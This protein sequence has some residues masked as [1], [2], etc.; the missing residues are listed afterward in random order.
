MSGQECNVCVSK[1]N[2]I[3]NRKIVC[4]KCE[5]SCCRV[6]IEKY[7]T[8]SLNDFHCMKCKKYWDYE[9]FLR[10]MTKASV[11]R[12]QKSRQ[13]V[14]FEREKAK[15][16]ATQKYVTYQ[17]EIDNDK[18]YMNNMYILINRTYTLYSEALKDY[19]KMLKDKE[20]TLNRE[21]IEKS[22]KIL[23]ET[24][25]ALRGELD[26]HHLT[27]KRYR[28]KI[29]KWE[30]TKHI[31]TT[32]DM[33]REDNLTIVRNCSDKDCKGFVMSD[34]KC[35]ICKTEYCSRCHLEE[36]KDHKCNEDD[37]KTA[38]LITTS[39]KPCPTCATLIQK[40]NGCNQMWCLT[41][42]S[43]FNYKTGELDN[44]MV[45]NPHYYEWF[46]NNHNNTNVDIRYINCNRVMNQAQ[47]MT[48]V[49][50][51]FKK[52]NEIA[53]KLMHYN[54]TYGHTRH[55]MN[56]ISVVDENAETHNLDLRIEWM[57]NKIDNNEFK[58]KLKTRDK[59]HKFDM[60]K[61]QIYD[62]CQRVLNDICHKV[63]YCNED[64]DAIEFIKEFERIV[65][66]SNEA[67]EELGRLYNY[68]VYLV[69]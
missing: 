22:I 54:R 14:L 20:I 48:H 16:P 21:H 15:M 28:R 35:G 65:E 46:R 12:I 68:K 60:N 43:A 33:N 38:A 67:L 42:K 6:C 17:K 56:S 50:L 19:N 36:G 31:E 45:H 8:T 69:K 27:M 52:N 30:H 4:P 3:L 51:A 59:R 41:C 61:R 64:G 7:M 37:I 26:E 57:M 62:M 34:W 25:R 58:A 66:Y 13:D 2:T 47:Y 55:L 9:F 29:W 63:I 39:T 23:N 5:Y 44:G 40:V 24:I 53:R 18:E 11:K 10:S 32:E 1:Y 49:N